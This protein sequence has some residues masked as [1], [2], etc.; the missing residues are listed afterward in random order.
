MRASLLFGLA[1]A[2]ALAAGDSALDCYEAPLT[3]YRTK[4]EHEIENI[5]GH[6]IVTAEQ[7]A[8]RA[9]RGSA[10]NWLAGASARLRWRSLHSAATTHRL[11]GFQ[12]GKFCTDCTTVHHIQLLYAHMPR[13]DSH[14][15]HSEDLHG[16][17]HSATSCRVSW[18]EL[19]N[20]P[21]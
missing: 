10:G 2:V 8:E 3:G 20:R 1:A 11:H 4:F 9:Q 19:F 16:C 6:A 7:C 14:L 15:T 12:K 13:D 5:Q 18:D 17:T 21:R